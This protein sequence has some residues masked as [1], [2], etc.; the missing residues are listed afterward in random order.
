MNTAQNTQNFRKNA[1]FTEN[2]QNTQI[3]HT[4]KEKPCLNNANF[5]QNLRK[6]ILRSYTKIFSGQPLDKN[7]TILL[8]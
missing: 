8:K 5:T 7:R 2:T 4:K 3:L 6:N 1:K